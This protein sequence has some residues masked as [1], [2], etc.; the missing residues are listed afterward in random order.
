[1]KTDIERVRNAISKVLNSGT[2]YLSALEIDCCEKNSLDGEQLEE[3]LKQALPLLDQIEQ[4]MAEVCSDCGWAM[5]F[6]GEEC[7]KCGYERLQKERDGKV[8]VDREETRKQMEVF[9]KEDI[10]HGTG[11]DN[12]NRGRADVLEAILQ[13]REEKTNG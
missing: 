11:W 3:L 12:Y 7:M 9:R 2:W 13:R 4:V 8:L 10:G 6:P 5:K 1:M